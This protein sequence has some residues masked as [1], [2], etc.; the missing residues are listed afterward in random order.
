MSSKAMVALTKMCI[1]SALASVTSS[2]NISLVVEKGR[3]FARPFLCA[4]LDKKGIVTLLRDALL[5]KR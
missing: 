4:A 1:S 3:A 5:L 2:K